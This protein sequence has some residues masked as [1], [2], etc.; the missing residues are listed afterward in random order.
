MFSPEYSY[1]YEVCLF[2]EARQKPIK[3]GS[4]F[5]LGY[6]MPLDAIIA[7]PLTP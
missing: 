7:L 3:G 6:I 5:S 1:I 2:D 4:T